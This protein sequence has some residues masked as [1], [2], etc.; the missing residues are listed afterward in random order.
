MVASAAA[1]IEL[2]VNQIVLQAYQLAGLLNY[3]QGLDQKRGNYAR[4]LLESIV[5]LLEADG[6]QVRAVDFVYVSLTTG[7][8]DYEF[9]TSDSVLDVFGPG[10]YIQAGVTDVTHADGETQVIQ[11][12][13]VAWQELSSK[14]AEGRPTMYYADRFGALV[15]VKLWPT[16]TEDGTIRFQVHKILP[17]SMDGDAS[18]P[19]ERPWAQYFIWELAH[20]LAVAQG[21]PLQKCGYL[22]GKAQEKLQKCKG[23]SNQHTNVQ[24]TLDHD[25]GYH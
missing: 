19:L 23:F 6:L 22:G 16:P 5:A 8:S 13:R 10:A 11:I 4:L 9:A 17:T 14:S 18:P 20:Q 12:D 1:S 15:K 3:A 7:T 24:I 2:S 25:A 21:K